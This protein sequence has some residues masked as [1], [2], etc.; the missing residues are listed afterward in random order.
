MEKVH[1]SHSS[2]V[3]AAYT[4]GVINRKLDSNYPFCS[5]LET[6]WNK[7]DNTILDFE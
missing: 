3:Q 6:R 7:F 1:I 4:D 2:A 5:F